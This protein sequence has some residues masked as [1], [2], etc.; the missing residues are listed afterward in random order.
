MLSGYFGGAVDRLMVLL[1]DTL[2]PLSVLLLYVV[3]A[4][5]GKGIPNAAAVL[6]VVCAP[7]YVRVLRNQTDQVRSELFVEAAP[8]VEAG[9]FWILR[10]YYLFRNVV[11]KDVLVKCY[12]GDISRK[13]KLL[14]K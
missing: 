12:G 4:F 9:P 7:Q 6:C 10:H 1:L 3:L 11:A 2:Y 14:K 13:E 8:S 5:L